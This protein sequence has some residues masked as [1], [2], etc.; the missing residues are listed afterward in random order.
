[1]STTEYKPGLSIE[2]LPAELQTQEPLKLASNENPL[3]P[4]PL[5]LQAIRDHLDNLNIYPPRQLD[6]Q[7]CQAIAASISDQL[8]PEHIVIGSG[9]IEVLEFVARS[10]LTT[11]DAESVLPRQTFPFL[12]RFSGRS[13]HKINFYDLDTD[14]FSYYPEQIAAAITPQTK[15]VYVC[16]PNNPTGTY[17]PAATLQQIIDVVPD[18][19]LLIHDEAYIDFVDAPDYPDALPYVFAGKNI[20]LMRTFAKIYGLAGLRLG[21]GI[22]PPAVIERVAGVKRN[23]H[24]NKLALIAGI[25]ALNDADHRQRTIANNAAGKQWLTEQ[26][27]RLGCRVWPSQANFVLFSHPSV[28]AQTM[29][30]WLM[31]QAIIVRPAFGLGNHIR[32]SI[33]TPEQNARLVGSLTA[34]LN[35]AGD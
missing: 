18:D 10:H 16:N 11:P 14:N 33:G 6:G 22:A 30:D 29:I 19:V 24:V 13:G 35:Q 20:F 31:A 3:G 4:S 25:A 27:T 9:G 28:P 15:L 12:A 32:L 17:V 21:Y 5:A 2:D 34:V 1:M 23:F 7:L 8:G 26:L